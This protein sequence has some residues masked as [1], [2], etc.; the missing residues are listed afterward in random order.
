MEINNASRSGNSN[1]SQQS[2]NPHSFH[3]ADED[4]ESELS[5]K[6]SLPTSPKSGSTN[7]QP[8]NHL[9]VDRGS[10]EYLDNSGD[11]GERNMNAEYETFGMTY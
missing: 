10:T 8:S 1:N 6:P 5:P 11:E 4:W 7:L 2:T 3:Q 9:N